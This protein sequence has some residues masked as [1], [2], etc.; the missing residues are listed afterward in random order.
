MGAAVI[1]PADCYI[2]D[3]LQLGG[4]EEL[5]A[6]LARVL[7]SGRV[8]LVQIREKD[9]AGGEL[10]A[11]VRRTRE[12]P[13][14]AGARI[15][16]N[17]RVDVALACGASGAHLPAGSP[18]PS[19][20]RG[21]TGSAFLIGVSTHSAEEVRAAE[22][23]G[24]DYCVFGPVFFTPSKAG[25]GEPKGV[26]RLAEAAAGVRI[27]VYALGGITRHNAQ[28]CREAGAAG[29]AGISMFQRRDG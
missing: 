12:L 11:L 16:V 1:R 6:N 14:P 2:T 3:R 7:A 10:A 4:V 24:A 21:L 15:V 19:R 5:L 13:N 22:R 27:P 17:S 28:L 18:P 26:A 23:E 8:A 29:V 9:L 25:F 20:W